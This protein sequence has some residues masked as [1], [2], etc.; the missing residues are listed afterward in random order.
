MLQPFTPVN[1]EV[2]VPTQVFVLFLILSIVCIALFEGNRAD[3][4][5]KNDPNA[6]VVV[7][8]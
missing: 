4:K 8:R 5:R 2:P 1:V 6:A 7:P 3:A